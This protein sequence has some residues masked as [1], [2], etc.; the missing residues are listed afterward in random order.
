MKT[1]IF[2]SLILTAVTIISTSA[3]VTGTSTL[4]PGAPNL[5]PAGPGFNN[6]FGPM[7]NN[8]FGT[9]VVPAN[10]GTGLTALQND[11][12]QLL[13]VLANFND[14]VD[15][16]ALSAATQSSATNTSGSTAPVPVSGQ[17]LST[18][19]SA[20]FSTLMS[21][22]VSAR[23]AGAPSGSLSTAI[24]AP[25]QTAIAP[26]PTGVNNPFGLA[27]GFGGP[28][29]T[30]AF[31]T[32]VTARDVVRDLIVLQNDL[33]RL[34]PVLVTLNGSGLPPGFT[35]MVGSINNSSS[36]AISTALTTGR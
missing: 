27:P 32:A 33:E 1:K 15:F 8:Q 10:F 16:S 35:N 21:R 17:N 6:V 12:Q 7:F 11:I 36:S 31:G 24:T 19:T 22:D 14:S 2:L 5:S 30:N 4:T 29:T 13:P 18:R 23:T 28:I 9:N 26:S 34:L 20:D 3:Q 25:S